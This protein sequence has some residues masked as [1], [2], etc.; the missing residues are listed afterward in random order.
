[1]SDPCKSILDKIA[2]GQAEVKSLQS[3]LSEG[4]SKAGL[5]S[6]IR[7]LENDERTARGDLTVCR[8]KLIE[9]EHTATGGD[10]GPLGS[11]TGGATECEDLRGWF[12]MYQHG[13]IYWSPETGAHGVW[14]LFWTKWNALHREKGPLGYPTQDKTPTP[15]GAFVN[16]EGGVILLKDGGTEA[17]E[18]HGAI[19]Q[20][21][22][23]LDSEKGFLGF[24]LTDETTP[25]DGVG[26]FNH[27]D[28]GSI[29]WKPNLGAHEVHGDIRA[30]W[31]SHH[32]ETGRYGYPISDE[33]PIAHGK[34]DRFSDFEDGVIMWRASSH[35]G[36]DLV[37][38]FQLSRADVVA[39][40]QKQIRGILTAADAR[41]YITKDAQ[42]A[43]VGDYSLASSGAVRDRMYTVAVSFGITVEGTNDPDV[44][45][46]LTIEVRLNHGTK[47]VEA[48]PRSWQAHTQ[49]DFPTTL[50]I[51][52][53]G[54][55]AQLKPK[56][57][58]IMNVPIKIQDA[59]D[60]T[61]SVKVMR[62][63]GVNGYFAISL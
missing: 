49:V 10:R 16:F 59:P 54:V 56:I 28:G 58:A 29:Y 60:G 12:A 52:A 18:V 22:I 50:G 20:H 2:N 15:G 63:G 19:R 24:P 62:D 34:P 38:L 14:G 45:L 36:E 7:T 39:L 1:M 23:G 21:Y 5:V 3:Q 27:F 42:I 46:T 48:I 40:I 31:Q 35:G 57:D 30:F 4:G 33:G 53:A 26:R 61:L 9:A 11:R 6:R 17:F 44:D 41:L 37:P 32:W 25:P 51:S 47:A 8:L 55:N 43:S 13:A